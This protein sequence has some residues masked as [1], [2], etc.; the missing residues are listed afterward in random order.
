MN[1]KLKTDLLNISAEY[2]GSTAFFL[3]CLK[4]VIETDN[5]FFIS[6]TSSQLKEEVTDS[7]LGFI[8]KIDSFDAESFGY[9]SEYCICHYESPIFLKNAFSELKV[10]TNEFMSSPNYRTYISCCEIN[11]YKAPYLKEDAALFL[12]DSLSFSINE[13]LD[14]IRLEN[15]DYF[16]YKI[17]DTESPFPEDPRMLNNGNLNIFIT[18]NGLINFDR[19]SILKSKDELLGYIKKILTED[20]FVIPKEYINRADFLNFQGNK[21]NTS[22]I[23]GQEI[24][25]FELYNEHLDGY[26]DIVIKGFI[27]YNDDVNGLSY[28][29]LKFNDQKDYIGEF[30][31][32]IPFENAIFKYL[33]S[34]LDVE[35]LDR[36]N[37]E[38]LN[39]EGFWQSREHYN[40]NDKNW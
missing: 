6:L 3:N 2:T 11:N 12:N 18:L 31:R 32:S 36:N 15:D 37:I 40:N 24:K 29:Y 34:Y 39:Y 30:P 19:I 9:N 10:K 21:H 23:V 5:K 13:V 28:D 20:F 14:I 38:D 7:F 25:T 26:H 16:A 8:N 17:R 27:W 35:R 4:Y 33:I 22:L 1:E